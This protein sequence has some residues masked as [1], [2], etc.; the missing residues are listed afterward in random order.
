MVLIA[1]CYLHS[2]FL[3]DVMQVD[4]VAL[5]TSNQNLTFIFIYGSLSR[6]DCTPIVF[7]KFFQVLV[8]NS[9]SAYW[10]EGFS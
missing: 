2:I 4:Q 3:I 1:V 5:Y 10:H 6:V 8:D 7:V 9:I